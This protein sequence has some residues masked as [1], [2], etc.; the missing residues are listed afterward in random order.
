MALGITA[1]PFTYVVHVLGLVAIILVLVWNIHFRGGLAW[2]ADNKNLI[3]NL[4]PVLMI[5]GLIFLGGEA[6]ISYKSLPL[7]KEVKKVIHLTLHAIALALGIF[8]ICAAFKNH[9]ESGIANLYSLHSWLGIAVI[10]LYGI[11]WLYGFVIFF[12][13]GG[14]PAIR[15][16]SLPWHVLFGLFVY[17]LAIGTASLGFLEKLTFLE[18]SGLAKYGSEALLVNFT[19]VITIL[20]GAFVVL[21]ALSDAPPAEDDYAPI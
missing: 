5:L 16:E 12:F 11:Q 17:V 20:F 18:N 1:V 2:D 14:T 13:P 15:R 8:G 19:A 10:S 3:F 7:K 9:N 6:I 21:S 4:H